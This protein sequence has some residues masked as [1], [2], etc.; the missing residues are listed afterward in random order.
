MFVF[1]FGLSEV[2]L[3]C[4]SSCPPLTEDMDD[5]SRVKARQGSYVVYLFLVLFT[6]AMPEGI[7]SPEHASPHPPAVPLACFHL[8]P[9][10]WNLNP[11]VVVCT[12]PSRYA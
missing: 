6:G 7:T 8:H 2:H 1:V 9:H 12:L 11:S 3:A 4:Q 10:A 5:M